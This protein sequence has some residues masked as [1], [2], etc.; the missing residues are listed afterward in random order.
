VP[1]ALALRVTRLIL[2]LFLALPLFAQALDVRTLAGPTSGGGFADGSGANARF[3]APRAIAADA[4]GNIY[5]ADTGNHAIRKITAAGAVSTIAGVPGAA[6][7][8]D[9]PAGNALFRFPAGIAVDSANGTI[10][11]S[12]KDNHVIRRITPD[13]Q[14]S[15][16]AG[17]PGVAGS[18]DAQGSAA[19]FAY[20][21]GLELDASG[22]IYVADTQNHVI[23]RVTPD[24]MVTKAAGTWLAPG[25]ANGPVETARFNQPSD[26]AIDLTTNTIFVADSGTHRIRKIADGNVTTLAGDDRGYFDAA[27]TSAEFDTPYG[28]DIDASGT[29][30]VADHS[31]AVV[32]RVSAGG[33]VTTLAGTNSIGTRDGTGNNARFST[34][35]GI[36]IGSDGAVYVADT[37]SHAIRRIVPSSAVVTT[38]AGSKPELGYAE[39]TGTTARFRFPFGVA[40]D[41]SGNIYV[42]DDTAVRRITPAGVTSLVAGSPGVAGFVDATGT[43]ARFGALTAIAFG[44]GG[45]LYV[46]D[47]SNNAVRR[48]TPAGVVTTIA[49]SPQLTSPWGIAVDAAST[50]YVTN[51]GTHSIV[52]IS[53]SGTVTTLAG[54]IRGWADGTGAQARFDLPSGI[55][56]DGAGNVYVADFGNDMVRKITPAG[57]VSTLVPLTAGLVSPSGI[58]AEADGDLYVSDYNHMIYRV[59]S[60]GVVT[61]VAG[62]PS[63]PGNVNGTA[64]RARF[65]FPEQ[66]DLTPNGD[67]VIADSYNHAIR[68]ASPATTVRRRLVRP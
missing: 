35:S 60:S 49:S 6:G 4:S 50:L 45:M 9:G 3:S 19:K 57:V 23:R 52:T 56:V 26:V 41:D 33:N 17:T 62:L 40:S 34:P 16:L 32:R 28:L 25:G 46:A 8:R 29:L 10:Y 20:P 63:S 67:L 11:V 27:G 53:P 14:V 48:I 55:T 59:T 21:R 36:A 51:L 39:G 66:I 47:P 31:N 12:D 68:I 13:G 38:L 18:A 5:V 30:Y 65:A 54:G 22:I 58:V 15:T 2:S 42:A 43:S 24:G 7:H 1:F 44:P 64:S 37:L 61:A